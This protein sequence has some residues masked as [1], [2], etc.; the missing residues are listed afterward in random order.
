LAFA[1]PSLAT[2]IQACPDCSGSVDFIA[3]SARRASSADSPRT[4]VSFGL[5]TH[6]REILGWPDFGKSLLLSNYSDCAPVLGAK[7]QNDGREEC[8]LRLKV[9]RRESVTPRIR[10][11]DFANAA[12]ADLPPFAAG[13][14]LNLGTGLS[15]PAPAVDVQKTWRPAMMRAN[16]LYVALALGIS[17]VTPANGQVALSRT[18]PEL[19]DAIQQRVD[20]NAYPLTGMNADDVREILSNISSLDRDEWAAAWMAKGA[21]YAARGA[22][23]A[24]TDKA[25][26]HDAYMMAFRYDSFAAWP[27]PNSPGKQRAYTRGI[28]DFRR[29]AALSD[30]PIE[31]IAFPFEGK[32]VQAYLALPVGVRPSPV[33]LAIGGLD[34]YK[35]YW[36][37]RAA[38]FLKIRLGVL[39]L[40]MPGTGESPV[41]VF[42][43]AEKMYS[44]AVDYLLSQRDVDGKRLAALGASWGGHWSAILSFTEME[45]FRGSVVW[46]GPIHAYFQPDWQRKA[47]GTR[48]YLFDLFPARAAVYGVSTMDDFLAFGP[49]MSLEVRGFIGKPSIRTL[50]VNGVGDTQVPIEDLYILQR[51]GTPKESWVNPQGGH[52]GRGPGW[53]DGRIF[54]EVVLPWLA[55]VLKSDRD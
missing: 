16:A 50:L 45:R 35:E 6:A 41:K 32:T 14:H 48:E 46:G 52:I 44:A 20:R 13:A 51:T 49:R 53:S 3:A 1:E 12:R 29:A 7:L 54:A 30:P 18:W 26:A 36:C 39:C 15:L 5:D 28:D 38:E 4:S 17:C 55:K 10:R 47:L 23:L 2:S 33:V 25:A 8:V 31:S 43:G 34:S 27:T 40:D 37:E 11:I 21:V 24:A 42:A 19:K 22:A 9:M